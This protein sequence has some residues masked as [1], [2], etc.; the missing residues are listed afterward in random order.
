MRCPLTNKPYCNSPTRLDECFDCPLKEEYMEEAREYEA[1]L[2][3][4][5]EELMNR[6]YEELMA[7]QEA[8][9]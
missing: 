6:E 5:Y 3:K 7:K 4:E 2:N 8:Q 9:E 1:Q